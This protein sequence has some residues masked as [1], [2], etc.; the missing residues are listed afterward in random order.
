MRI[1]LPQTKWLNFIRKSR[2]TSVP[3]K[4]LQKPERIPG[5]F[6]NQDTN[7][8]EKQLAEWFAMASQPAGRYAKWHWQSQHTGTFV[9]AKQCCSRLAWMNDK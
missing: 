1:G 8:D 5:K 7:H 6:H 4:V 2:L 9:G 3:G